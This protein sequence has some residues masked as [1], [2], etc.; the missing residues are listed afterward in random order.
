MM[1]ML[2]DMMTIFFIMAGFFLLWLN[3][4]MRTNE[5]IITLDQY[6]ELV[7]MRPKDDAGDPDDR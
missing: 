5:V 4:R 6:T 7:S 2:L 1:P 3:L